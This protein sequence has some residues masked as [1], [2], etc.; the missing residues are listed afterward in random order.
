MMGRGGVGTWCG[1]T[2]GMVSMYHCGTVVLNLPWQGG[3]EKDDATPSTASASGS[4]IHHANQTETRRLHTPKSKT[5]R[6]V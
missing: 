3:L 1:C 4:V 2:H 5:S 6:G